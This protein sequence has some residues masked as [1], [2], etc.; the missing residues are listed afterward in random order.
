MYTNSN[1]EDEI[2]TARVAGIWYL[3]MAIAGLFGFMVLHPQIFVSNDP[4]KTLANLS[5]HEFLARLRL[6]FELVIIVAQ[7]LTA[8]WF[9]KLFKN[10][11]DWGAWTLGIWGTMNAGVIM[12][13]AIAMGSALGVADTA[14]HSLDDKVALIDILERIVANV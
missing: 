4:A 7:A 6:L 1:K 14:V 11:N 12:I 5:E 2:R 8:V 9:Y 13:S 10:I 3:I